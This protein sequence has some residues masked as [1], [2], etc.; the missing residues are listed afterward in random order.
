ML[1]YGAILSLV[2]LGSEKKQKGE[3]ENDSNL[4]NI[5]RQQKIE[6]IAETGNP[7]TQQQKQDLSSYVRQDGLVHKFSNELG[8]YSNV[9]TQMNRLN[10]DFV[11]AMDV[12]T[13]DSASELVK[14]DQLN[15]SNVGQMLASQHGV[16]H[17]SKKAVKRNLKIHKLSSQESWI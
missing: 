10:Y 16:M 8:N 5:L 3:G 12:S 17:A 6:D 13:L 7:P 11:R 14:I 15:N 2:P 4:E 9:T 1:N